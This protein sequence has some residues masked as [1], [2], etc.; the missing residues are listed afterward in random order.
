MSNLGETPTPD[1]YSVQHG[2]L[3]T[4]PEGYPGASADAYA[5]LLRACPMNV[6][7]YTEVA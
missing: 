4:T 1:R 2:N 3:V 7:V 5:G 6:T